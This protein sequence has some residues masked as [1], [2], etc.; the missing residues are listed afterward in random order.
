MGRGSGGYAGAWLG[1]NEN[2]WRGQLAVLKARYRVVAVNLAGHGA[3]GS[4]RTD[5]SIENYARDVA[6]IAQEV[7]TRSWCW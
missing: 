2:Y 3:S 4:N 1:G 7:R 5:W 6:A